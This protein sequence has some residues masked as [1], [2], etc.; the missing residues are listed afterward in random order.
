[1]KGD[2]LLVE[3]DRELR[4][5]LREGLEAE[6]FRVRAAAGGGA[7]LD[8]L[9]A[10]R[11]EVV[12]SDLRMSGLGGLELCRRVQELDPHLPVVLMTAFGDLEAAVGAM[13]AG[14]YDFLAKPFEVEEL[15]LVL[16]RAVRTRRLTQQVSALEARLREVE[17]FEELL[18]ESREVRALCDLI[19][20]SARADTTVLVLGETGSG[21]ELVA[22][23][24]HRRSPR[25]RGPFV[26]I[27]CAAV[28]AALLES[29]LFGHTKGAFTGAERDRPGLLQQA[30][31][32]TLFLD[33]VGDM[34]LELQAK[35]LRVLQERRA[36]AVGSDAEFAVDCR[37]VAATHR[38]LEEE[39]EAGR[40]RQDLLY[41]I[42]VI[43]LRVPPLR[44]RGNDVLL[45]AQRFVEA[46]AARMQREV[47][48]ISAAAAAKLL[49]YDWPGNVRELENCMERAVALTQ[50]REV[51]VDD[52]P[53]RVRGAAP[54]PAA[55]AAVELIPLEQVERRHVLAV[56][57]AVEGNKARAASILRIGRKTLYRKLEHYGAEGEG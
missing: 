35:L 16:E 23:A 36:R 56:L 15:G 5:V 6:G 31:G 3:D 45:L 25:A 43:E 29:E 53:P 40:F 17:P 13:R 55:G 14:A 57:N 2:V 50:G 41:R 46:H 47:S 48:G 49:A 20:R 28:P 52:L 39:V 24:L 12:L 22:R 33:E 54:G 11:P 38:D 4:E 18:G 1:M 51:V 7:A 30:Q 34:P 37:V 44:D 8:E 27:N 32:G 10:R 42:N 21:K 26:A 19:A 9:R